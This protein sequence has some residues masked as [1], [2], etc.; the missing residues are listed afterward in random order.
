MCSPCLEGAGARRIFAAVLEYK[1]QR[2]KTA[3]LT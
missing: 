1:S 2:K 3:R